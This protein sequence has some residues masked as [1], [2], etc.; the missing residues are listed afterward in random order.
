VVQDAAVVAP[1]FGEMPGFGG[2]LKLHR[3]LG[4]PFQEGAVDEER[5]VQGA[6]K[7]R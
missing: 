3:G 2:I 1:G 7:K 6:R 4:T 5:G